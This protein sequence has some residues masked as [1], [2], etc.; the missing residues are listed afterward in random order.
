VAVFGKMFIWYVKCL[1]IGGNMWPITRH[2]QM[3]KTGQVST[4]CWFAQMTLG[5]H[6]PAQRREQARPGSTTFQKHSLIVALVGS[7]IYRTTRANKGNARVRDFFLTF[8]IGRSLIV[9]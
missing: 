5:A 1:L 8:T 4:P 7:H 9:T 3:N 2:D 6:V